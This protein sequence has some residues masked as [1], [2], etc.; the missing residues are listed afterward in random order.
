MLNE[1]VALF[2]V[3]GRTNLALIDAARAASPREACGA[4]VGE[5][6]SDGSTR[7]WDVVPLSN[8]AAAAQREY[9]IT[10]DQVRAIGTA[11]QAR[12]LEVVGFYH[13]HPNGG[14][15][16]SATD[17]ERAWPGYVY[18]IVDPLSSAVAFWVLEEDRT[19]FRQLNGHP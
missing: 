12:G 1:Q 19:S 11:A 13:S 16:P 6:G 5:L 7:V 15:S 17:L 18:A 9:L 10:A 14:T 2:R 8:R 3:D 4:L